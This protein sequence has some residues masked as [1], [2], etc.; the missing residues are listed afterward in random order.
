MK[1]QILV[2]SLLVVLAYA[3][4]LIPLP[5]RKAAAGLSSGNQR[6]AFAWNQDDFWK[7]IETQYR[8]VRK[9]GCEGT[10]RQSDSLLTLS[11]QTLATIAGR[12]LSPDDPALRILERS[13]FEA[14]SLAA[15]CPERLDRYASLVVNERTVVKQQSEHWNIRDDATREALYRL[16][17]GSRGALEEVLLHLPP[18]TRPDA[19]MRGVDEP[20]SCPQAN[21]L[22]VQLRSGDILLSRGGAA[23]SALIARGNDFPGNFSHVALAYV[24]PKTNLISIIEAHIER[25][26]AVSTPEQYLA[27]TK[28]RVMVLRLRHDLPQMRI[29]TMLPHKAAAYALALAR[30]RHTA[31]DF[32]MDFQ[33]SEKLFCSEVASL[34][35]GQVGVQLWMGLSHISSP[36]LRAW[37]EEFGVEHFETQ[38]PSDLEYDPQ[39]RVVA[40]WRD[41]EQLRKDHLDNAVTEAMLEGAEAGERLTFPWY[42]LPVGRGAKLYS[43]LLNLFGRI[44][45]IPEGMTAEAALRNKHYSARHRA[46]ENELNRLAGEFE[47]EQGYL[48]PY[49]GLLQMARSARQTVGQE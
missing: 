5:E 30:G 41:P 15:S 26:V 47:K 6:K 36:G 14:G 13:V 29:D 39:L 2:G 37:L 19:L 28:L 9:K 8:A 7:Q 16:L 27:D 43:A 45:P 40:E 48:P 18:G 44:G 32:S 46:I 22:G 11:E 31:Y 35:Y 23:T 1:K 4:L 10:H 12:P 42:E 21:L 24:D 25:G 20:S 17:Y 3:L 33:N 38:E 34:A 49:W